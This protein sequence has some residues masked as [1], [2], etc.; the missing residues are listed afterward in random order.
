MSFYIT[1]KTFQEDHTDRIP[2][3]GYICIFRAD[4]LRL[5][6]IT[7]PKNLTRKCCRYRF[8]ESRF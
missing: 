3:C 1:W 6:Y 4:D 8:R 7:K 2:F 5:K